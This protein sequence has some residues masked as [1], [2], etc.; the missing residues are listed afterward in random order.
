M[1][2]RIMLATVFVGLIGI[3]VVGAVGRTMDRTARVVEAQGRGYGRD[4]GEASQGLGTGYNQG[5]E[6]GQDDQ[7]PQSGSLGQGLGRISE[8]Q[9]GLG[10]GR[11]SGT[12]GQ[13]LGSGSG[14]QSGSD[15]ARVDE[16]LTVQGT[17]ISVD[18]EELHVQADD[19]I[20]M[21]VGHRPWS[22][23]Q[24]QD[25]SAQAGDEVTL[26]GF[27]EGEEFEVGRIENVTSGQSV[28]L[29]DENGRPMWAGRGQ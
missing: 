18:E 16:W 19:G 26:T 13:G 24:E 9:T 12:L 3:L 10:Q 1:W 23:A 22:F 14:N 17:V 29:R 4:L 15:Q 20:L 25:F 27:Y 11:E 6:R 2:K 5:I 7:D 8:D 21:V 28:L